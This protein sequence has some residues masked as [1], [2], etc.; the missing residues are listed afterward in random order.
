LAAT[1]LSKKTE[2]RWR[3]RYG[4]VQNA[5]YAVDAVCTGQFHA[6]M[7]ESDERRIW[8]RFRAVSAALRLPGQES[9]S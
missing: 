3:D 4:C 9:H 1:Y 7:Q 5:R 8:E 6:V 2:A